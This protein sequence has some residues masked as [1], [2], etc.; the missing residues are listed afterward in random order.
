MSEAK[1]FAKRAGLPEENTWRSWEA[2]PAKIFLNDLERRFHVEMI[3]QLREMGVKV[4]IATTSTWGMN[5]LYS[6]P[7]LTVGDLVDAHVYGGTLELE[8]NPLLAANLVAWMAAGQVVGKP[9]TITE[10]NV[11]RFPVP[12]RHGIPLYVAANARLQGWDALMQYAYAQI[13]LNGAGQASNWHAFN[14]PAMIATLPAA[15][16]LYRQAHVDEAATAYVYQPG[17]EQLFHR[18]VSPDNSVALR[19]AAEKG[20]LLIALPETREL[21]WLKASAIPLGARVIKDP[22]QSLIDPLARESVSDTGQLR[23]NWEE[24]VYTINTPRSQAVMG[25][26][27]GRR[28]ALTDVEIDATTRNAT[29]AVQSMDGAPIGKSRHIMISLGARSN[30]EQNNRLPFRSEPVIGQISIH[31]PQGMRMYK[32]GILQEFKEVPVIYDHGRYL[33]NLD[34]AIGTSWLFLKR[35]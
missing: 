11:E 19:T 9:M 22:G 28:I 17:K 12:D 21:P 8:K 31:A 33:I 16:L 34:K 18:G 25:W 23:R 4:P 7:A 5:P 29:V 10:W 13:P 35:P 32:R 24:G 15:A 1:A 27:G 2:G 30:P 3:G 6:L 26:V 20:K 14:D